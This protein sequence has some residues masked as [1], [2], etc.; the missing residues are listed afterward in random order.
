MSIALTT[1][2]DELARALSH[3]KNGVPREGRVLLTARTDGLRLVCTDTELAIREQSA[4]N[5][6]GEGELS[7]S[8]AEL[9]QV[10]KSLP[11]S[12]VHLKEVSASRLELRCG[13]TLFRLPG[14]PGSEFPALPDFRGVW[15]SW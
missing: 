11:E 13:Q 4:A 5:V 9:L 12:T 10:V 8:V 6:I 1:D 7:V 14:L 15:F 2:R 3:V